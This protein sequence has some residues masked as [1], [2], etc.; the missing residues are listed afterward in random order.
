MEYKLGVTVKKESMFLDFKLSQY[1]VYFCLS[2][3]WFPSVWIVFADVL[4]HSVC[5]IFV[6]SVSRK[7]EQTECS[8]M[9]ANK[10]QT[11]GNHPRERVQ[12]DCVCFSLCVQQSCWAVKGQE[13]DRRTG[14]C[15]DLLWL[16]CKYEQIAA[17]VTFCHFGRIFWMIYTCW[18]SR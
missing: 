10:I 4:E 5:W 12:R 2:F 7:K 6:S 15:Q 3:A 9:S 8:E 18:S 11:P 14:A 16:H 1:S 13:A 17:S